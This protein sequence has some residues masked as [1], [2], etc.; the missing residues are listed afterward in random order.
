MNN[1]KTNTKFLLIIA[2]PFVLFLSIL[3]W[4]SG[5][6]KFALEIF[7]AGG[8]GVAVLYFSP[9]DSEENEDSSHLR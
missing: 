7:L 6:W 4:A 3:A 5:G 9:P 8:A 1:K 2:V